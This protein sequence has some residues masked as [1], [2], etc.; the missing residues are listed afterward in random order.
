MAHISKRLKN[1]KEKY[2]HY[3]YYIQKADYWISHGKRDKAEKLKWED[4][5]VKA[6]KLSA[7]KDWLI[8]EC[9]KRFAVSGYQE[10][11]FAQE[12]IQGVQLAFGTNRERYGKVCCCG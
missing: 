2:F 7:D 8:E 5:V 3:R 1:K 12:K 11:G 10:I 4:K 9:K 6:L